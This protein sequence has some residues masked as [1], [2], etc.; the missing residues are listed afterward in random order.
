[1]E[2]LDLERSRQDEHEKYLVVLC[3]LGECASVS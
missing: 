2:Y 1:M 3:I